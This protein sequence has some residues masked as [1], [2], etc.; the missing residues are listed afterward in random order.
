MHRTAFPG[1]PARAGVETTFGLF[2]L[3]LVSIRRKYAAYSTNNV[4]FKMTGR[5]LNLILVKVFPCLRRIFLLGFQD[6][7]LVGLGDDLTIDIEE[8]AADSRLARLPV[9][10]AAVKF[11]IRNQ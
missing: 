9:L 4:L 7:A 3:L 5:L 10:P 11:F 8:A 1:T 2:M 6:C